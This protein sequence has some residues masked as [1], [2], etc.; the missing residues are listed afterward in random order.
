[1]THSRTVRPGHWL[2]L[3]LLLAV[4][5]GFTAEPARV[6]AKSKSFM[7]VGLLQDD[8]LIIHLS[9]LLDNAPVHDASV[10]VNVRALS[11]PA[12]AQ[13]DGSYEVRDPQLKADGPAVVALMVKRGELSEKLVGTL[14]VPAAGKTVTEDGQVR[15][16]LWWVL[17]FAVCIGFLV[18]ISRRRK[19]AAGEQG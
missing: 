7:A 18:L 8:R 4:R 10:Q 2:A 13:T 14:E 5:P 11:L 3:L 9:R 19:K 6:E 17:N 15:Q 1:M 12:V 16:L